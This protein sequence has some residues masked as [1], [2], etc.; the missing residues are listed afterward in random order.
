VRLLSDDEDVVVAAPE[1]LPRE[2]QRALS[3]P[4]HRPLSYYAY[5]ARRAAHTYWNFLRCGSP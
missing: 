4:K 1:D 3:D 2:L 5:M